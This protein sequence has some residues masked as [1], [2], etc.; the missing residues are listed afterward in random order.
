MNTL[1]QEDRILKALKEKYKQLQ[2]ESDGFNISIAPSQS[3]ETA[4][5]RLS[6]QTPYKPIGGDGAY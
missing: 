6:S 2:V 5:F 4:V 1:T 3:N